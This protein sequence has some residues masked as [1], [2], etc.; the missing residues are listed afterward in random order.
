[1]QVLEPHFGAELL[2]TLLSIPASKTLLRRHLS[3]HFVTLIGNDTQQNK[4]LAEAAPGYS[5]VTPNQRV[6]VS[7]Y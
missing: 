1:M 7:Y 3:T 4:R 5:P 6:K 2:C